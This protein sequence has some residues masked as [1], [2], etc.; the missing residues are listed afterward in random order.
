MNR[1]RNWTTRHGAIWTL[2][3]SSV[4]PRSRMKPMKHATIFIYLVL[5][6]LLDGAYLAQAADS[7]PSLILVN[8]RICTMNPAQPWAE[9]MAVR[10][11]RIVSRRRK[12]RHFAPQRAVDADHRF[13]RR[14]PDPGIDR[15]P[16]AFHRRRPVLEECA[17]CATPPPWRE[18]TRRVGEYASDSSAGRLDSRARVGATAIPTC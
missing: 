8:G 2:V 17:R 15:Q 5:A 4:A 16:R 1:H 3:A 12:D 10:G 13:A 9:A 7:P 18:V 14:L 6:F 11:H